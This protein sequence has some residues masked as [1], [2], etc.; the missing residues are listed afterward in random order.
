MNI[1]IT[2]SSGFIGRQLAKNLL[3]NSNF[4][5]SL[6]SRNKNIDTPIKINY[7]YCDLNHNFEWDSYLKNIDIVIHLAAAQHKKKNFNKKYYW[8]INYESTKKLSKAIAKST[9]TKFIYLSTI[10]VY[11]EKNR[12]LDKVDNNS[13]CYPANDYA[14]SKYEAEN[15]ILKNLKKTSVYYYILRTPLVYGPDA[16][17]NFKLLTILL[18]NILPNPLLGFYS[19][20]SMISIYNLVDF[21]KYIIATPNVPSDIYLVSDNEDVSLSQF[22]KLI[23]LSL[24]RKKIQIK[25]SPIFFLFILKIL[26]KKYLFDKMNDRFVIDISHTLKNTG[27]APK[28][29]ISQSLKKIFV[30]K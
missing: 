23:V 27:W 3:K 17:G 5:L 9:V 7:I 19:K 24:N 2:G 8:Q 20:R 6:V 12:S 30:N 1:L 26:N 18:N 25:I 13:N 4:N 14:L 29:S 15:A 21:I 28:Y 10:K 22:S 11:G 16:K